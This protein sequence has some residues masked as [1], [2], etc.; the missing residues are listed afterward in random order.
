MSYEVVIG[1]R[2]RK[3]FK[4]IPRKCQTLILLKLNKLKENPRPSGCKK[5]KPQEDLYR[6]RIGE[7]RVIYEIKD[8]KLI[9]IIVKIGNRKNIYKEYG[10]AV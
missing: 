5:L 8:S 10:R 9:V 2:V 7:Y 4:A 6:I 1:P 3:S